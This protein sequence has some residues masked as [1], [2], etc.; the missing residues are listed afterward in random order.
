[1]LT[2]DDMEARPQREALWPSNFLTRHIDSLTV[3]ATTAVLSLSLYIHL[4]VVFPIVYPKAELDKKHPSKADFNWQTCNSRDNLQR[5]VDHGDG[6]ACWDGLYKGSYA[7]HGRHAMFFNVQRETLGIFSISCLF[8]CL[9]FVTLQKFF[10]MLL[11]K[12][13]RVSAFMIILCNAHSMYYHWWVTLTYLNEAWYHYWW[14]QWVFGVT[15]AAVMYVLLL[16]IDNRFKVQCAHCVTVVSVA[17]FHMSQGLL[18]QAVKNMIK[19]CAFTAWR[20]CLPAAPAKLTLPPATCTLSR[21]TWA[22]WSASSSQSPLFSSTCATSP[23]KQAARCSPFSLT[24]CPKSPSCARSCGPCCHSP[25]L[26]K[27]DARL[28]PAPQAAAH[29][30]RM[31]Q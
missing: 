5:A 19:G 23:H 8:I 25:R 10:K 7:L 18:T 15:E 17:I 12:R 1:M 9:A 27:H 2:D 21:G 26:L 20:C 13:L 28:V 30:T 11:R 24:F 6:C 4:G 31:S 3:L 14:S 16:R 29:G 22:S